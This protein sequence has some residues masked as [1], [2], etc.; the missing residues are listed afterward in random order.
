MKQSIV[1]SVTTDYLYGADGWRV[2]KAS[3]S[4]S[5]FNFR[6]AGGPTLTERTNPTGSSTFARDYI[7]IAGRLIAGVTR[8]MDA[9]D[10]TPAGFA[11]TH[12][13]GVSGAT[14]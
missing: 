5:T 14:V 11:V 2:K 13:S 9:R 10:P 4:T 8:A 6:G 3:G 7:Y 12:Q 1:G